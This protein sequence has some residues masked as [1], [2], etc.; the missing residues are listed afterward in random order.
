MTLADYI[1]QNEGLRLKVYDDSRGIPS[2]GWGRDLRDQGISEDEA[3]FLFNNDLA[4]AR[5]GAEQVVTPEAWYSMDASRQNALVDM[6]FEMGPHG[7]AE[8][9]HML[10]AVRSGDWQAAH[11]E[12]LSSAYAR[13]VPN[14]ANRNAA[15]LLT[16]IWPDGATVG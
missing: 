14:R 2:I 10:A 11:D 9:Q 15:I 6:C 1:K 16:G 12:L 13:E 8:F 5:R 3:Q 7:L 4:A